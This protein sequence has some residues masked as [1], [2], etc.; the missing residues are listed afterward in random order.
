M[1]AYLFRRFFYM[2]GVEEEPDSQAGGCRYYI[3]DIAVAC[4]ALGVKVCSFANP[5]PLA[6]FVQDAPRLFVP[7]EPSQRG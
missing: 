2:S 7:T 1:A 3:W 5:F 6:D 4:I